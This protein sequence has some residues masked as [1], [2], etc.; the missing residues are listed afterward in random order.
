MVFFKKKKTSYFGFYLYI[1]KMLFIYAFIK[2]TKTSHLFYVGGF[3]LLHPS[4]SVLYR[5]NS[6]NF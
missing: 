4:Y 2:E 3:L 1:F 5:M 6:R